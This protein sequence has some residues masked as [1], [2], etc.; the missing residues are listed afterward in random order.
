MRTVP[1][2]VVLPPVCA[3][4]LVFA[5]CK[6]SSSDTEGGGL[7]LAT[8]DQKSQGA[9]S[10]R[11]RLM[12]AVDAKTGEHAPADVAA[13]R[14]TEAVLG[15]R[16]S[17]LGLKQMVFTRQP[18]DRITLRCDAPTPGQVVA[19]RKK[20]SDTATLDFR[21]VHGDS[22]ALLAKVEAKR[23]ILDPD[24]TMFPFS[25]D[26]ASGEK[27]GKLI[28][29]RIP[30]ITADQILSASPVHDHEGWSLNLKFNKKA[31]TTF[32]EITAKMRPGVDRFAIVV[33]GSI[34]SAPTVAMGIFGGD[35]RIT[36]K[37]S[38]W[39]VRDLAT[40]LM[41]PLRHPVVIEEEGAK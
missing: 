33:N 28:V 8:G 3:L 35:C 29:S 12:P 4:L 10:F 14:E 25:P 6:R 15:N 27:S 34:V 38:E 17:G 36:G 30:E 5:G 26:A 1:L 19:I 21:T 9:V 11:L 41:N 7:S 13:L 32:Y 37:F 22:D 40:S 39:E 23:V 16:L 18:P 20:V 31:A 2:R 24:W